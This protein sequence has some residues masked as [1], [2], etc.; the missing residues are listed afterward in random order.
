MRCAAIDCGTNTARL[1]IA[2]REGDRIEPL[3]IERRIIRLGGGF[4][5][6]RGIAPDA[7]E[8]GVETISSFA[9]LIRHHGVSSLRAVATSAVRDAVNGEAFCRRVREVSGI[10]LEV[11]DGAEEALL[12]L[13]GVGSAV[14]VTTPYRL[15]FDVGG[16]STE[17]T[18]AEGEIPRLSE[19]LPFGVV[20]LTEGTGGD[21]SRMRE[22]VR[23]V[24]EP[25][26]RMVDALCARGVIRDRVTL[27]GTAGTATTLAAIHLQMKEYDWRRVNGHILPK[28]FIGE[29]YDRLLPLSPLQRLGVTGLEQGRE[30]LI[31]AG[32]IITLET[33]ERFGFDDMVVSDAGLLEGV[34]LS[35]VD[36]TA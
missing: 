6:E 15:V 26:A 10:E 19:S 32:M 21:P 20:R 27:I 23:R 35:I 30:D 2:D 36:R 16:G 24:L 9:R 33:M 1:L 17:Y 22:K 31:I 29:V 25:F 3:L 13:R 8:R 12:T 18:L 11:I 28:R 7:W 34:L 5:K 14:S 4:T